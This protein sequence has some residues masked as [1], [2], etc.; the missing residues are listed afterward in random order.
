MQSL[1]YRGDNRLS[2]A[3]YGDRDGD[4]VLVQHGMIASIRDGHLFEHLIDA[5]ARLICAARPG[6]GASSPYVMVDLAEWGEIVAALVK[7][8]DLSSCDVLGISSGAPYA[9]AI[10]HRLPG[11]VRSIYILSGTPA[12]YEDQIQAAW[13]YPIDVHAG[14]PEL[15]KLARDLFFSDLSESD[16][17]RNDVRDSMEHD[18]F[19]IALDLRLRCRQ[20]GF[21]LSDVRQHVH[22]RH[23]RGDDQVPFIAA[24]MTSGL[25]PDCRFEAVESDAH[26]S[27]QLLDE[28][29]ESAWIVHYGENL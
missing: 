16:R 5:G 25:L 3:E 20:W 10:G 17:S 29:V 24:E 7:A 1:E 23:S 12:L 22:M 8:L 6:Y 11:V 27:R 28:F 15:Q 13:P 2:Y 19:G 14:I 21:S 4:P 18:C 9:Y 26:F